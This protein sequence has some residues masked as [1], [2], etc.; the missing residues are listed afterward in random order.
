MGKKTGR[1]NRIDD[2]TLNRIRNMIESLEFGSLTIKVH[3]G[4]IV[5]VEVTE[6]RRFDD[7]SRFEDGGGI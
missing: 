3:E 6:K 2:E 1:R 7:S 4:E 5:Q